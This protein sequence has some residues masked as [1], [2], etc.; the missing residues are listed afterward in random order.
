MPKATKAVK[1]LSKNDIAG[2]V[3]R[4][5]IVFIVPIITGIIIFKKKEISPFGKDDVLSVDLWGQYFP[6][7]RKFALDH[8]FAE[9]MYNWSGAL[10]FNNWLQNAFYTRSIFL[11]PFCII[12]FAKSITYI[13]IVCLLRFGLGAVACQLFLE[14]KLKSKSPVIMAASIGYGLCA[15][16][17]AFIMQ[18]MWTDGLFLGPLVL[19]GLER[20]M[21]GK[22]P[23]MYVCLLAL[24]IYSNFYTGFGICLFTG[25]YFLA[26]WLKR[27]Y[28][29]SEGKLP[30][31]NGAIRARASMFGRFSL[32]SV[33][34]G[35]LTAFLLVPTLLGLSNTESANQVKFDF[36]C[37]YHTLAENVAA[38]M[39]DTPA[40]LEFG[41]AN[42]AVGLFAFILI[43]LYFMNTEIKFKEKLI[44]GGF[45][46]VLYSGLN[47]NPM[48]WLF[49][50]FHFPNQLPGRWSFLF[51]FAVV[52]VAA[53]GAARTKGINFRSIVSSLIIALFFLSYAKHADLPEQKLEK[54]T[55]WKELTIMYAM[56]LL[57]SVMVGQLAVQLGKKAEKLI[58][59]KDGKEPSETDSEKAAL[60]KKKS[61]ALRFCSLAIS[62]VLAASITEELCRDTVRITAK[63]DGGMPK[64][65]MESYIKVSDVLHEFGSKYD[66]GSDD[67]YRVEVNNGWTFNSAMLGD[68]KGIGYYG[69]TLNKNVYDL[70]RGMGNRIYAQNVSIVYNNSSLFQ[71]SFFG[72]KYIIDRGKSFTEMTGKGYVITEDAENAV[73][74]ENPTAFPIA[75][76]VSDDLLSL[77]LSPDD[78]RGI[79]DQN[80]LLNSICGEEANVFGRM[81]PS[82]LIKE[83]AEPESD[84]DSWTG[85]YFRRLDGNEPVKFTWTY[86][87][88]D[89]MPVYLE[90]NFHE[91]AIVV[92]G[93]NN[94]DVS[95]DKFK[96]LGSFPAGTTL[97]VE[98]NV[99]DIDIGSYGLELY[100]FDLGK[101]NEIYEN[102]KNSGIDVTS[103]KNT[104]IKGGINLQE[105]ATVLSTV[106]QD[107]GWKV[108]VD[109]KRVKD[110]KALGA[111]TAFNVGAGNHTIELKYSVPGFAFGMLITL[112]SLLALAFCYKVRRK[113]GK[114]LLK[115]QDKP[116][117]KKEK[118]PAQ[119]ENKDPEK[120]SP[121]DNAGDLP[122]EESKEEENV[123]PQ[124]SQEIKEERNE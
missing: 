101:W 38:M 72:I 9:A 35:T 90:S 95:A 53:S 48:D 4:C 17:T 120:K 67:L 97:T 39:P 34:G 50:G 85:Q 19:L 103:F 27:D 40:S 63:E 87:V 88:P 66:C 100:R 58:D 12:P 92:N 107:G 71:N 43:P 10:G 119:K 105:P 108:Y 93:T 65:A 45:L 77:E 54:L 91:G 115:K 118:T 41:V 110:F 6:M 69:S 104:R 11:I 49:N 82:E 83:N 37:W 15:Y 96:C 57:A 8:G 61:R 26:E 62:V 24:S 81:E 1:K 111:L 117:E 3:L 31:K 75:F 99:S 102:V 21:N 33:L 5:F 123:S 59:A 124:Y 55:Y 23:F 112:L 79:Y 16:S 52:I 28:S 60:L 51:S 18:F 36:T 122:D 7:Y 84:T 56:L 42:I 73:I 2:I 78:S 109:G 13:D 113:G 44:T 32:Y 64:S 25:F 94:I 74:L 80:R 89:E 121:E 114:G 47:Y 46:A 86:N 22:S 20:L 76:A 68:F 14:Y 30:G 70:F 98:Y 116:S 106:P 29:G